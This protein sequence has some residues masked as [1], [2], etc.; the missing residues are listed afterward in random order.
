MVTFLFI[1]IFHL[2]WSSDHVSISNFSAEFYLEAMPTHALFPSAN[3]GE[4]THARVSSVILVS[5]DILKK[6]SFLVEQEKT[7]KFILCKWGV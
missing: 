1:F 2:G 5:I 4:D 3:V 6:I 7:I